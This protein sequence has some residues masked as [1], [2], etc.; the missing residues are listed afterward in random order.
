MDFRG[1]FSIVCQE[2]F[3]VHASYYPK[4][5]VIKDWSNKANEDPHPTPQPPHPYP[6]LSMSFDF[7]Y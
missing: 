4:K 1:I 2:S 6:F 7:R 3:T 5:A